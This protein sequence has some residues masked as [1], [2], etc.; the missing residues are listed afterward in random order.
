MGG[1]HFDGNICL[2]EFRPPTTDTT[3][4]FKAMYCRNRQEAVCICCDRTDSS[5][6]E[7][8]LFGRELSDEDITRIMEDH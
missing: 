6:E 5:D 8:V 2:F 7:W 3:Y 4:R 1:A